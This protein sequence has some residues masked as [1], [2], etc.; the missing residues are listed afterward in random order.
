[1]TSGGAIPTGGG[2]SQRQ[3]VRAFSRLELVVVVAVLGILVA[4]VWPALA[5]SGQRSLRL[6]CI[7]N[8]KQMGRGLQEFGAEHGGRM[9]WRTPSCEGGTYGGDCPGTPQ[10]LLGSGLPNNIWFQA[11]WLSNELRSPHILACP[12]DARKRP[13]KD[14]SL[15]PASGFLHPN[16]QNNAVSYFFSL[17]VFAGDAVTVVAGDRNVR[18]DEII[19]GCSSGVNPAL[20]IYFRGPSNAGINREMHH[21]QGNF[22]FT[23]GRI[24]EIS[25]D[26]FRRRVNDVTK[27]DDNG[28]AH[29]LMPSFFDNL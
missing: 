20:A 9:P 15:S 12:S 22:L 27:A 5:Q 16:F 29:Y 7:G 11:F 4:M 8:L 14:W 18:G 23:D 19:Q 28:S 26:A 17:D 10:G 24:E 13:A 6:L 1:M 21:E 2:R 3:C 25:S